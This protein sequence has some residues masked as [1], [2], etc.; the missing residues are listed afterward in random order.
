MIVDLSSPKGHSVND[1]I[2]PPLC[3][4]CYATVADTA[5]LVIDCGRGALMAKLDLRAAYG[6]IPVHPLNCLC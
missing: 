3:S 1:A 6:S 5:G 4:V 2:D